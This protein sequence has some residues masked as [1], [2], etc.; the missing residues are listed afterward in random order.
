MVHIYSSLLNA[1]WWQRKCSFSLSVIVLTGYLLTF[2]VVNIHL[3]DGFSVESS[4]NWDGF[5][6]FATG[7]CKLGICI[8]QIILKLHCQATTLFFDSTR[9]CVCTLD[10]VSRTASCQFPLFVAH[11]WPVSSEDWLLSYC[12]QQERESDHP[13]KPLL[14][15]L[16]LQFEYWL[17]CDGSKS[18]ISPSVNVSDDKWLAVL[19]DAFNFWISSKGHGPSL[20]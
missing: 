7:P 1:L 13:V 2:K 18:F 10:S 20:I 8:F 19:V 6:S 14:Q 4:G 3:D 15:Y 16:W 5:L 9:C 11:C 17:L 12:S